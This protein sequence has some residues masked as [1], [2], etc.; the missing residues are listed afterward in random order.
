MVMYWRKKKSKKPYLILLVV[1]H[2]CKNLFHSAQE[3]PQARSEVPRKTK[4]MRLRVDRTVVCS[5]FCG[6]VCLSGSGSE[7][8]PCSTARKWEH[9]PAGVASKAGPHCHSPLGSCHYLV[10][11]KPTLLP[12]PASPMGCHCVLCSTRIPGHRVLWVQ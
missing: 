11:R 1:N 3:R 9:V 12:F 2:P 6:G 5:C 10:R 7:I 4:M 8:P